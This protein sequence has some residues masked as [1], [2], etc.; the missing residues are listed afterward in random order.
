MTKRKKLMLRIGLAPAVLLAGGVMVV[1]FLQPHRAKAWLGM[2]SPQNRPV[3]V[4]VEPC[5]RRDLAEF[6]TAGGK[7][8]PLV[9]VKISPEVS[10]EIVVLPFSE[11]QHVKKG[12]L[13]IRIKPDYYAAARNSAQAAFKAAVANQNLAKAQLQRA[14]FELDRIKELFSAKLVSESQFQ[15]VKTAH[16]VAVAQYEGAGHQT[17]MARSTVLRADEDVAKTSVFSPI[18]G[19]VTKLSSQLGERVVGTAT[20]A[21][22]EIMQIAD[23]SEMEARVEVGEGDIILIQPGQPATLDV[24]AVRA[25]KFQGVVTYIANMPNNAGTALAVKSQEATKFEVRIRITEAFPFRPG[26]SASATIQTRSRTQVLAVPIQC[27]TTRIPPAAGTDGKAGAAALTAGKPIEVVFVVEGERARLRPIQRG[28]SDESYVEIV[29]GLTEGQMVVTG[30]YKA[31]NRE[32][33]DGASITTL[34]P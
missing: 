20:M 13:I 9:L 5:V 17:E 6:V 31:I 1:G 29:S 16:D 7:I 26:M 15:E 4:Q 19:V 3:A 18:S 10:G 28:I 21:G 12:D 27:V 8:Q 23:L 32:L 2:D 11:G 30:S 24:D 25:K 33:Q 34:T 22:T 14:V